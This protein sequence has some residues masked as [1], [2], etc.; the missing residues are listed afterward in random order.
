MGLY[1]NIQYVITAKLIELRSMFTII[2]NHLNSAVTIERAGGA[3]EEREQH[4][5]HDRPSHEETKQ[6]QVFIEGHF[7]FT[8]N[9][10]HYESIST[11]NLL[12]GLQKNMTNRCSILSLHRSAIEEVVCLNI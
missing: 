7:T 1:M 8:F 2:N 6:V 11:L 10:S 3:V 5:Q 12:F 4:Q 9:I